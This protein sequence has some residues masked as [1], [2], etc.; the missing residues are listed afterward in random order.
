MTVRTVPTKP[1]PD[2]RP[3]T[4][5]LRRRVA[6]F[7]QP[8]Y[9]ANFVQS[10]FDTVGSHEGQTLIVGGDG[11]FYNAEA[12]QLILHMAAANGFARTRVPMA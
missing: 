6:V 10:I 9:L 3:G 4:A 2:M 8:H 1:Y 12:M 11:R 5:G 7:R